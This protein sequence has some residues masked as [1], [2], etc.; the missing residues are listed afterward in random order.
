MKKNKDSGYCRR[1]GEQKENGK[2]PYCKP[3]DRR[4]RNCSVRENCS[5][6]PRHCKKC[7]RAYEHLP[8]LWTM[9]P[10]SMI[11]RWKSLK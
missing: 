1:C 7:M 4:S 5:A 8:D 2:C 11:K 6:P 9:I 10:P 3:T